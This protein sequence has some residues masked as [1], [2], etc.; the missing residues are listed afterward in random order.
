[1]LPNLPLLWEVRRRFG[2]S[3]GNTLKARRCDGRRRRMPHRRDGFR[4]HHVVREDPRRVK[5]RASAEHVEKAARLRVP[6]H[7]PQI[8]PRVVERIAPTT[9]THLISPLRIRYRPPQPTYAGVFGG[10][11]IFGGCNINSSRA[12]IEREFSHI[13][14]YRF[15][16]LRLTVLR[17][18]QSS[19]PRLLSFFL[20]STDG[21]QTNFLYLVAEKFDVAARCM[22]PGALARLVSGH[23]DNELYPHL[24]SGLQTAQ[25]F[26]GLC[27]R[28]DF[29]FFFR[30]FIELELDVRTQLIRVIPRFVAP[31]AAEYFVLVRV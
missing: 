14:V 7:I 25:E 23:R 17:E 30:I 5:V 27:E 3:R 22:E 15:Y 4:R 18:T 21:L 12:D 31:I 11:K 10:M 29:V 13:S 2:F 9:R 16:L 28:I 1:M 26:Q 8:L 19:T 6:A 24:F 20:G